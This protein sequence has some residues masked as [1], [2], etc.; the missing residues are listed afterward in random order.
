MES[1]YIYLLLR[2]DIYFYY[3]YYVHKFFKKIREL[4]DGELLFNGTPFA[5]LTYSAQSS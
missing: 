4:L 3:F 5:P 1:L 2:L